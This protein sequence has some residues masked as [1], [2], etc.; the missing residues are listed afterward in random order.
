MLGRV[1]HDGEVLDLEKPLATYGIG[2]GSILE[3][4]EEQ[5]LLE[6]FPG[7]SPRT[8]TLASP[9]S[10]GHQLH[11]NY[12]KAKDALEKGVKPKLAPAGTGGSYFMLSRDGTQVLKPTCREP[13][14]FLFNLCALLVHSTHY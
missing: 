10:P 6:E 13:L 9:S 2:K 8:T 11:D 12:N 4:V 14:S 7:D 3:L 1:V 5:L